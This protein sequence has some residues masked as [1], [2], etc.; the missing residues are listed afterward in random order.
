MVVIGHSQGGLLTKLT[1]VDS[2][3]RFWDRISKKPFDEVEV[4][5]ETRALLQQ[6]IFFTPLPFVA[7]V[8][9]V[10]TPHHGAIL[11][12]RRLGALAARLI[13]LPVGVFGGLAR[14]VASTGDA[15][16]IAALSKPPTA[17]DNMS[18]RNP[19]L[20]ILVSIPVSSRIPAHSIIAV[21]GE[22]PQEEGD[23]GVVTYQS[24]HIDGVVSEFVV[25]WD[26]SCQGQPE[27]I[28]EIRRILLEHAAMRREGAQGLDREAR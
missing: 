11:A 18:P 8:V 2:G 4:S 27:V 1:A 7:R 24:A 14:A 5:P 6:S 22:G 28:E 16:L 19:A 10:A 26:H 20:R 17:I 13:T 12:G 15:T 9:F 21:K 23:D 3:T 25:R